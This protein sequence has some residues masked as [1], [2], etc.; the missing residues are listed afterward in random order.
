[1]SD[2]DKSQWIVVLGELHE[3]LDSAIG[4][5]ASFEDA[6]D[7]ADTLHEPNTILGVVP[8]RLTPPE[9]F[10]EGEH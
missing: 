7:Y 5:F 8:V 3:G 1:M 10:E 2:D 6:H 4:P 9:G